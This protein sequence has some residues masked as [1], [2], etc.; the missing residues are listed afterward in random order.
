MDPA[1]LFKNVAMTLIGSGRRRERSAC[2][3]AFSSTH[4][5]PPPDTP[6]L[7]L[8]DWARGLRDGRAGS[9]KSRQGNRRRQDDDRRPDAGAGSV[10]TRVGPAANWPPSCGAAADA[11]GRGAESTVPMFARKGRASYLGERSAGPSRTRE[12]CRVSL[13]LSALADAA[14]AGGKA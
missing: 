5:K 2:T 8:T 9:P 6:R 11:A 14:E 12:R 3:A 10:A 7:T 1:T 4:R 13:L